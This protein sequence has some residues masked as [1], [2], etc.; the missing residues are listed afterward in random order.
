MKLAKYLSA[1]GHPRVGVVAGDSLR[2]LRAAEPYS[3]LS[4]ILDADSPADVASG[5]L[6]AESQPLPLASVQLLAPID[7]QEV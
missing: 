1:A 7:R 5:L 6:D 4:A 2:P 3:T